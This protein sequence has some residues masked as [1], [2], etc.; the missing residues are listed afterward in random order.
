M[1]D[2]N[3]RASPVCQ[4]EE[5]CGGAAASHQFIYG[6]HFRLHPRHRQSN[7][8]LKAGPGSPSPAANLTEVFIY[9]HVAGTLE[10]Q[11]IDRAARTTVSAGRLGEKSS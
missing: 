10:W 2:V 11:R 3:R 6:V 1:Q 5:R 8:H 9:E 4:E 7:Y